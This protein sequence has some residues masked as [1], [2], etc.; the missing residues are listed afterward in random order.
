MQNRTSIWAAGM[1]AAIASLLLYWITLAPT[2]LHIDCGELAA[3][4]TLLGIA[5]ATGYPLFTLLGYLFVKI[6]IFDRPIVQLNFLAALWTASGIGLITAW[7]VY[8][9][10]QA[11]FFCWK[12]KSVGRK[13]LAMDSNLTYFIVAVSAGITVAV[14]RT[15][16]AQATAVEVYSLHILMLSI[17]LWAITLAWIKNTNT[18]WALAA[19]ALGFSFSNHLTTI[20]LVPFFGWF[21]FV[22]Q[23]F[24]KN[25]LLKLAALVGITTLVV[26]GFYSYLPLRAAQNPIL[27]WGNI[28]DWQTFKWHITGGQF[29]VWMF[30]S[31]KVAG[32][33]L[34]QFF[35]NLPAEWGLIGL[36]VM[37]F[38]IRF[39]RQQAPILLWGIAIGAM[40]NV[41]YAINYDIKDLEPYYL[42]AILCLSVLLAF[43]L[44]QLLQFF[45]FNTGLKGL[46][47]LV[48]PFIALAYNF[49]FSNQS[50]TRFFEDY[51][52]SMMENIPANSLII[53][54]QWDF[55]ITPYYYLRYVENQFPGTVL[56]DKELL[57]RS[58]YYRQVQ[59]FDSTVLKGSE[60][61]VDRFLEL[62]KPF[63][64]KEAFDANGLQGTYVSIITSMIANNV[65]KRPVFITQELA[66]DLERG[67]VQLPKGYTV[68]P[69]GWMLQVVPT[70]E[71]Y[72][73][74]KVPQLNIKFPKNWKGYYSD[75]MVSNW[76]QACNLRARYEQGFGKNAEAEAWNMAAAQ[77]QKVK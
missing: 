57:R 30:S 59:I 19:A 68:A 26:A 4:Q 16:W 12:S 46:V 36:P 74:T 75:F 40:F 23:G 17:C 24:S 48:V 66:G 38:G 49:N 34:G 3:A 9:M 39:A 33:N 27:N 8:L 76:Y 65:N 63:E 1:L 70:S 72:L 41:F 29:Q 55:F 2:M 69:M 11:P 14:Q 64:N 73:A 53:S 77:L 13:D 43:G 54:Q 47:V 28:H 62:V 35:K 56:V 32:K 60:E 18:Y 71:G 10:Q 44:L 52:R 42:L 37:F 21:Y 7:L 15:V 6:P 5:H 25:S 20:L 51:T 22:Q 45:G 31:A 50:K 67:D 61:K 58:W